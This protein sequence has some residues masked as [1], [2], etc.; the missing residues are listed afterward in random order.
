MNLTITLFLKLPG[1]DYQIQSIFPGGKSR[2]NTL[3]TTSST[4][5]RH[6]NR[7]SHYS[8]DSLLTLQGLPPPP[9][10]PPV[11]RLLSPDL[12]TLLPPPSQFHTLPRLHRSV[13]G[14]SG[15]GISVSAGISASQCAAR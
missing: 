2:S 11:E 4:L 9:A 10:A 13:S 8:M 15:A 14:V 6:L 5:P 7:G 12:D 3:T 1:S